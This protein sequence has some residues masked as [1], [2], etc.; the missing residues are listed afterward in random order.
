M[1]NLK[2]LQDIVEGKFTEKDLEAQYGLTKIKADLI[3]SAEW[4]SR[5]GK[6]SF[7]D[8]KKF[9]V[10]IMNKFQ[11]SEVKIYYDYYEDCVK[12][13]QDKKTKEEAKKLLKSAR[14]FT[15]EKNLIDR[16][17]HNKKNI[18]NREANVE[19]PYI[20]EIIAVRGSANNLNV[21]NL[22]EELQSKIKDCIKIRGYFNQ[23]DAGSSTVL[24]LLKL[25]PSE[26]L[27]LLALVDTELV[28]PKY[29]NLHDRLDDIIFITKD[30]YLKGNSSP[31]DE[32]FYCDCNESSEYNTRKEIL[33]FFEYTG[34]PNQIILHPENWVYDEEDSDIEEDFGDEEDECDD[35]PEYEI[36]KPSS[37]IT[38]NPAAIIYFDG[39]K[40]SIIIKTK[41]TD[42][43]IAT[44][45]YIG[46]IK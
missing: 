27:E 32:E 19:L 7:K 22:S 31:L 36:A 25:K 1:N 45:K 44:K 26:M 43:A 8:F 42:E 30:Q 37:Y 14:D 28:N 23:G 33:N 24:Y 39:T 41:D 4:G 15:F 20:V 16:I 46:G 38:K 6:E 18:L 34:D 12:M 3:D 9:N 40:Y 5:Y 21:K 13:F 17:I 35:F 10:D 2:H 11:S 29:P